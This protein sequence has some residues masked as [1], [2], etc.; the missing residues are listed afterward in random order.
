MVMTLEQYEPIVAEVDRKIK[1]IL[2]EK[3]DDQ[4][5]LAQMLDDM[6]IIKKAIYN[7]S[8]DQMDKLCLQ[9]ENFRYYMKLLEKVA[10]FVA[11]QAY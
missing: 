2:Q 4:H 11:K 7:L 6:P 5:L 3:K 9:Y 1:L 10:Q 8:S